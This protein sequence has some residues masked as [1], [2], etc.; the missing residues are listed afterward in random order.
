MWE[1]FSQWLTNITNNPTFITIASI[2]SSV[3]GILLIISRTSF[4]KR[5]IKKL[6]ELARK[7]EE[8]F[9]THKEIVA[10]KITEIENKVIEAKS[11]LEDATKELDRRFRV[12]FNQFSFYE[13]QMFSI[14]ELIP[15]AKV[16]E[17]LKELKNEWQNKKK[18]IEEFL[19]IS[20]EEF[21][22][23]AKEFEEEK[24]KQI[25]ELQRQLDEIK[26]L[27]FGESKDEERIDNEAKEE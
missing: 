19:C 11:D 13:E 18:E 17:K 5:A 10:E 12:Y 16:Q 21:E 23:K 9:N 26:E 8:S 2:L 1:E 15:N 24:N 27:V 20:Y 22:N 4:G 25:A 7:T 6:T 14:L 3:S